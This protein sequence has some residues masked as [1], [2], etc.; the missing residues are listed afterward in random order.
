MKH[1]VIIG[2]GIAGV[3]AARYI[4]KMSDY[5][6]TM[7]SA[8]S[9][10]F[11]SRTALMYVYMGH[12]RMKEITPYEDWFWEKNDISLIQAFVQE[13]D[14]GQQ[15]VHISNGKAVHY[16]ALILATGSTFNK[17]GWPGQDL[18][19]V[20]GLYSLQDLEYMEHYT[21]NA[22]RGVIVGGGLIGIE[23]AEM[24]LS[25]HIDVSFLVRES[26]YWNNILPEEES[27][28]I[29][30]HIR[31]HHV[32]LRLGTELK[33]IIGNDV[34]RVTAVETSKG[35]IIEC[36]W[37][38]LTAGVR[39]NVDFL[40][41][42]GIL[43]GRGIR[44]NDRFETNV[45]G[46]YA[47]GDCAEF[48]VAPPGRRNLEQ[49]WYSGKMHGE[50]VAA[51]ICGKGKPYDPGIFFNSAKF[52]DIEYQVY[53]DVPA[54]PSTGI[55]SLYWEHQGGH[56][57]IRINYRTDTQAV[58]GFNLMGIRYRHKVC[59]RWI[60]EGRTLEFVLEHLRAANF[61]PEFFSEY[62]RFLVAQYNQTHQKKIQLK[63]RR[64]L[65]DMIFP[66]AH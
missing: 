19:G 8:E 33:R 1:V 24:L 28:M 39:P 56:H 11:F 15:L 2:N 5:A 18:E 12:M 59:E 30:R 41:D 45:P 22:S 61:D 20:G 27:L 37:V 53:G 7:I 58:T 44:I 57:A 51:N 60:Q 50:M 23:M 47:I 49:I 16:D 63:S 48:L 35:E 38:G 32:D 25:R 29:S 43:I 21:R 31:E 17:F 64:K 13:V 9:K 34:G 10:Y 36:D 66:K 46:I 40:R 52:F 62:E 65:L 26:S 3:T 6:I 55:S 4:R 54:G 42:S 14:P